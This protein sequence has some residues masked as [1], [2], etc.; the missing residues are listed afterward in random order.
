MPWQL[1]PPWNNVLQII[2]IREKLRVSSVLNLVDFIENWEIV[3]FSFF[4]PHR[5]PCLSIAE[6]TAQHCFLLALIFCLKPSPALFTTWCQPGGI[7]S[8][9]L[10]HEWCIRWKNAFT[11]ASPQRAVVANTVMEKIW[12]LQRQ[13]CIMKPEKHL[14]M[15]SNTEQRGQ[16]WWENPS[17]GGNS[18]IFLYNVRWIYL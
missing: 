8:Q 11:L 16:G 12:R 15:M 1:W 2:F 9:K 7:Q 6:L 18:S 10:Y 13:K 17:L 14:W 3:Q 5:D 4:F